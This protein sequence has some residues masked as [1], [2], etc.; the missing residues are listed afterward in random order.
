MVR[1]DNGRQSARFGKLRSQPEP[2]VD[3]PLQCVARAELPVCRAQTDLP[4]IYHTFLGDH[5]RDSGT[6]M[7]L[8]VAPERCSQ[9]ADAIDRYL[10][11]REDMNA[12]RPAVLAELHHQIGSLLSIELMVA[13]DIDH[14]PPGKRLCRPLDSTQPD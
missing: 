14:R 8:E 9:K 2:R 3:M 6:V 5:H 10:V 1:D 7:E 4:V 13:E 12:E 11:V